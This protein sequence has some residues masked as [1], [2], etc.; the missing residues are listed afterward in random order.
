M[1]SVSGGP[2]VGH[3]P[4]PSQEA[5]DAT[6]AVDVRVGGPLQLDLPSGLQQREALRSDKRLYVRQELSDER[7]EFPLEGGHLD[8]KVAILRGRRRVPS[9]RR[10]AGVRAKKSI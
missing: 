6:G 8:L 5:E 3:L 10:R 4:Q 9:S 1:G 7:P 2:G